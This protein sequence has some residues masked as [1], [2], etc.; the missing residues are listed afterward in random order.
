[1]FI[2][3]V[4]KR[5]VRSNINWRWKFTLQKQFKFSFSWLLSTLFDLYFKEAN[6]NPSQARIH[7]VPTSVIQVSSQKWMRYKYEP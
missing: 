2:I 1:M 5:A 6:A 7:T 4:H 3:I